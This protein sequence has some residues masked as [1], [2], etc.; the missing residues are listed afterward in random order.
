MN[1]NNAAVQG[2]L[3]SVHKDTA[4]MIQAYLLPLP[5]CVPIHNYYVKEQQT[6]EVTMYVLSDAIILLPTAS[7]SVKH[8]QSVAAE[9][10]CHT[11]FAGTRKILLITRS[12]IWV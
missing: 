3:F 5:A 10:S 6:S 1:T 4:L 11:M 7:F 9:E 12:S 8:D 2:N